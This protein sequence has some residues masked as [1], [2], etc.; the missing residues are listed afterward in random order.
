MNFVHTSSRERGTRVL[1]IIGVVLIAAG[2]AGLGVALIQPGRQTPGMAPVA[3][4]SGAVAPA[5]GV[6]KSP[7]PNAAPTA[8]AKTASPSSGSHANWHGTWQSVTPGA[9]MV[10]TSTRFGACKWVDSPDPHF[11]GEC[12]AGYAPASMSLA[13]IAR[14]FEE[15]VAQFQTTPNPIGAADSTRSREF[16]GRIKPASYRVVLM[17]DG[18]D[19]PLTQMIIDGDLILRIVHCGYR[20]HISLFSRERVTPPALA[21]EPH[22]AVSTAVPAGQWQGTVNQA[23]YPP[24]PAV[25][26]LQTTAAGVPGGTMTYPSLDCTASLVFIRSEGNA[27]WFRESVLEGRGRCVDGGQISVS[28]VPGD[29]LT[30]RYFMSGN[31]NSPVATGTFRR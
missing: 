9:P 11:Q 4:K 17:F 12:Q 20:Q 26:Q 23:G 1:T 30:W 31:L 10:I 13:D 3:T 22:G 14:S 5:A 28:A 18:S 7:A 16:I 27:V 2:I 6:I 29:T 24:Y 19:C 8:V 15:S 21:Q 25:M